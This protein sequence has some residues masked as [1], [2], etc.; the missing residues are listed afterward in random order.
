MVTNWLAFTV[1]QGPISPSGHCTLTF[2]VSAL[3]STEVDPSML[4]AGVTAADSHLPLERCERPILTS[5]QEPMPSRFGP[6]CSS[7]TRNPVTHG[8]GL[9]GVTGSDIPPDLDVLVAC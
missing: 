7:C 3:P 2:T 8:R 4:A 1:I 6:G 9:I 5:I